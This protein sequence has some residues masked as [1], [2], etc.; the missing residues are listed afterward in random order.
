MRTVRLDIQ[1]Q[2]RK[3]RKFAALIALFAVT[4][5]LAGCGGDS[6]CGALSGRRQRYQQLHQRPW[7]EGTDTPTTVSIAGDRH[8]PCTVTI[9]T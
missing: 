1:F 6:G 9:P 2:V 8:E 7:Y 4:L 5:A 3:M